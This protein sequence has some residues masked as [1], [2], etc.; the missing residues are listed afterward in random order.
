MVL[1]VH[2]K[3]MCGAWVSILR[4]RRSVAIRK[5]QLQLLWTRCKLMAVLI[6]HPTQIWSLNTR[7]VICLS[8][9]DGLFA[10]LLLIE[11]ELHL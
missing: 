4:V 1:N 9:V 7:Q 3:K 2:G 8:F 5:M 11:L 10:W 6:G